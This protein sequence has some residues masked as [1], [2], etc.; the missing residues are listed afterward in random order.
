MP[1][2]KVRFKKQYTEYSVRFDILIIYKNVGILWIFLYNIP[3]RLGFLKLVQYTMSA[4]V[5]EH[6][7]T[8]LLSLSWENR[9]LIL[10]KKFD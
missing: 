7:L 5:A 8:F 4:Q 1:V 10:E 9:E 6:K 2:T 3:L